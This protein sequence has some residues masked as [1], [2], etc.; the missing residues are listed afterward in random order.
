MVNAGRLFTTWITVIVLYVI[1]LL[2]Y[3]ACDGLILL[4]SDVINQY[5]GAEYLALNN[6]IMTI[7]TFSPIIVLFLITA[8]GLFNSLSEEFDSDFGDLR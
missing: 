1:Y 4:L 3:M 7:W 6:W 2:V 5:L 8:W